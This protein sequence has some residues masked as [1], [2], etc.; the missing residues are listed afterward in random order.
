M[1]TKTKTKT[2]AETN[3]DTHAAGLAVDFNPSDQEPRTSL[4][5]KLR[6]PILAAS[7]LI[8]GTLALSA[9]NLVYLR[10]IN[11]N[12]ESTVQKNAGLHEEIKEAT[13]VIA[14]ANA[15]RTKATGTGRWLATLLN[16]QP[17]VLSV[18][19]EIGSKAV[20]VQSLSL[21]LS[22]G[23]SQ[24][25]SLEIVMLGDAKEISHYLESMTTRLQATG[26][27][28]VSPDPTPINGGIRFRGKFIFPPAN[29]IT[30]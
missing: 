9:S 28:L 22:E 30:Y 11:K 12:T 24:I 2:K 20:S 17:F 25:D 19:N 21:K 5:P 7:A 18:L 14:G 6:L 15:A 10:I 26:L 16:T 8:L 1:K 27:L 3:T 13:K 4:N 29:V 23:Q